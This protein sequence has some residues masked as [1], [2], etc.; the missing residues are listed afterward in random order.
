MPSKLTRIYVHVEP[1]GYDPLKEETTHCPESW[2]IK[3]YGTFLKDRVPD[4]DWTNEMILEEWQI[5]HW[6]EIHEIIS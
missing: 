5:A 3:E 2:I 1:W 4:M 6:S